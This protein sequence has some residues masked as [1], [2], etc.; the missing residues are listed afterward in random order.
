MRRLFPFVIAIVALLGAVTF[1]LAQDA[2]P[3]P[4]VGDSACATPSTGTPAAIAESTPAESASPV[5]TPEAC[6][7]PAVEPFTIELVDIAFKPTPNS[8]TPGRSVSQD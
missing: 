6:G 8:H 3:G 4:G 7:S 2:T 1:A 5:A